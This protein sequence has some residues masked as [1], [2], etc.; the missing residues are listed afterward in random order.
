M[1]TVPPSPPSAPSAVR[2]ASSSAFSAVRPPRPRVAPRAR[3]E[4]LERFPGHLGAA[5]PQGH[6]AVEEDADVR[7]AQRLELV[8][9]YAGD[10]RRIDFEVRVL[11][12]GPDEGEQ[13][14]LDGGQQ[15]VLLGLVEAVDL[16]E[17]EDRGRASGVAPVA[18]ALDHRSHLGS[19]G[20][21]GAFLLE[22]RVGMLGDDPRQRRLARTRRAVQDHRMR[23]SRLD[24]GAQRR[25]RVEQVVLADDVL[26]RPRAQARGQR[27]VV[28]LGRPLAG[29]GR[30][31]LAEQSLHG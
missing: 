31:I 1:V 11:R 3:R 2:H 14:V 7:R 10:E 17:E 6:R 4:E 22:R 16:V 19:P 25:A 12:R 13:A 26:K 29:V 8:H 20:G 24:R 21:D 9:L 28:R 23:S 15:R 18:G 27:R 30:G 5:L